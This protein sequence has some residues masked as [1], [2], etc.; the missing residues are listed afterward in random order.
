MPSE[1]SALTVCIQSSLGKKPRKLHAPFESAAMI[2]ARC[3]ILLSPGTVI[4]AS[5][6]G[7]LFTRSSIIN[8]R[9]SDADS[10]SGIQHRPQ[11]PLRNEKDFVGERIFDFC[12]RRKTAH[13]DQALVRRIRAFHK[14]GFSGNRRAV[15]IIGLRGLRRSR[16]SRRWGGPCRGRLDVFRRCVWIK[17]L[18]GR[19]IFGAGGLGGI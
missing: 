16:R 8:Q 2:A 9:E 5:I 4:S 6:R 11:L 12:A 19:R 14:T 10:V 7:A 18:L 1:R 13:I 3:E 17:R 15:W